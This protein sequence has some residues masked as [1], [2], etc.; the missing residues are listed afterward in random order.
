LKEHELELNEKKIEYLESELENMK[1]MNDFTEQAYAK[2]Q[3]D[4]K[5]VMDENIRLR[6]EL[7][8]ALAELGSRH[9][10]Q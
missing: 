10:R 6:R 9:K 4:H 7:D 2:F 5:R 8:S 3:A 1:Q